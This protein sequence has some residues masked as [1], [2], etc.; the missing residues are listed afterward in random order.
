MRILQGS[1]VRPVSSGIVFACCITF[2][3]STCNLFGETPA[4]PTSS[5][6]FWEN[7]PLE[8][9]IQPTVSGRWE[10]GLFGCVRNDGN[11]FHEGIDIAP[12]QRDRRGEATDTVQAFLPGVVAHISN[13]AG[14]SSYGRYVVLEHP[15]CN[16]TVYS[17]Y[18]HLRSIEPQLKVGAPVAKGQ[19]LGVMGRSAAGYSIPKDRAHLHFEIGLRLS[20][21]FQNWYDKQQFQSPNLHGNFNG[22]NLVGFDALDY[23]QK[24]RDGTISTITDYFKQL[25]TDI[26]LH[27]STKK[28]PLLLSRYPGL[29]AG[30]ANLQHLIGWNIDF[31]WYGLPLRFTP[32]EGN[33]NSIREN[34][35]TILHYNKEAIEHT[36]GAQ[37]LFLRNDGTT[38][39]GKTLIRY[40]QLIFQE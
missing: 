14:N 7:A 11:R 30:R 36:K 26:T 28:L 23:F 25:D 3:F 17:L 38:L 21:R 35:I 22:M 12:K 13:V 34:Q 16:P 10:S 33:P 31:T 9:I 8:S 5:N 37:V 29:L 1:G 2:A 18:A 19:S 20:N 40:L 15:D 4:W 27:Y 24:Y 6:A 32:V 39:P